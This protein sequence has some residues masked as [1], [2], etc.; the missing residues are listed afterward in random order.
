MDV[1]IYNKDFAKSTL[2]LFKLLNNKDIYADSESCRYICNWK[3]YYCLNKLDK[4]ELRQK[5][6]EVTQKVFLWPKF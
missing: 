3:F 1:K 5:L 6:S 2:K 4:S